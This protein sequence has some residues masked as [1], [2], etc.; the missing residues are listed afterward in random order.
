MGLAPSGGGAGA[1]AGDDVLPG[2]AEP[3]VVRGG[4]AGGDHRGG[5]GGGGAGGGDRRGGRRPDRALAAAK[6]QFTQVE[7]SLSE[8]TFL[9]AVDTVIAGVSGLAAVSVVR[10]DG[11]LSRSSGALLTR[12]W[13]DPLAVP[14]LAGA[15]QRT[16]DTRRASATGVLDLVGGQRFIVFDPV[17]PSDS[18]PPRAIL[19]AELEALPIIRS[20]LSQREDALAPS[21]YDV[22]DATGRRITTVP[23][24]RG[25]NRVTHAVG[26][27][28]TEWQL[29]VAYQPV[30]T[31]SFEAVSAAIR[32]SGVLLALGFALS[33]FFLW[34]T[35][36]AQQAEIRL[37]VEAERKAGENA[38]EAARRAA[39]AREVTDQLTAAQRTAL[40]LVG[41]QDPEEV[42]DIFLGAV[43]EVL[44]AD[45]ALLY[46]FEEHG[47]EAV[48]RRR[49]VLNP[50]RLPDSVSQ[51]D[52]QQVRVPVS[53]VPHLAEPIATGEPYVSAEEGSGGLG[54]AVPG[55]GRPAA[56]LA[57]PLTI[58]DHL[59]G[60]AVWECYTPGSKFDPSVTAF[61]R[62]VGA[63]A[64]ASLRAADLLDR[65]GRARQA[66]AREASRLATVLDRLADG[67]VLF[68][69]EGVP[70]RV[71]PAAE[72]L[73]GERV[74][75]T[76]LP[77]WPTTLGLQHGGRPLHGA[78]FILL[79]ALEGHRVEKFRF[80]VRRHGLDRF[81]AASAAPIVGDTESIQGVA[82]V[83]RDITDEHEYAE[84]LRHT[85]D[86]LQEQALLLE[87]MNDELK[88][89]TLAKDQFLAMMSHELRTPINAIIGYSDILEMGVHGGLNAKQRQMLTRVVETSRH[90]LGLV[91]DVLDLTKVAAGRMDLK[92]ETVAL[93]PVLMKAAHQVAPLAESKGLVVHVD[94]PDEHPR[95]GRRD[96][97]R[98]GRHQ[99]GLQRGEVHRGGERRDRRGDRG[100]PCAGPRAGHRPR[101]PAGRAG[102]RVR[103]VPPAGLEPLPPGGRIGARP[104]HLQAPGPPHGGRPE[105]GER[106]GGRNRL[107][108]GP[109]PRPV[110]AAGRLPGAELAAGHHAHDLAGEPG[111]VGPQG[112]AEDGQ[113]H[114]HRGQRRVERRRHHRRRRRA[115]HVGLAPNRQE[116]DRRLDDDGHDDEQQG[117]DR[118]PDEADEEELRVLHDGPRFMFIPMD[119]MSTYSS[120]VPTRDAPAPSSVR[121][122]VK[123]RMSP[124]VVA[125]TTIQKNGLVRLS[126]SSRREVRR[127]STGPA[128][129]PR[130]A[131]AAR[132]PEA[133]GED[134]HEVG[135]V[136][137]PGHARLVVGHALLQALDGRGVRLQLPVQDVR[138]AGRVQQHRQPHIRHQHVHRHHGAEQVIAHLE[139]LLHGRLVRAAADPA[140]G[141]RR[142]SPPDRVG[143]ARRTASGLI[144]E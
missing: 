75:T 93:A 99:P 45:Q 139:D 121:S 119:A 7:D 63:Q 79:R 104:G 96:P 39:E 33:L 68:D 126:R 89:A 70:V 117:V 36:S 135:Q 54:G 69:Q 47:D 123:E 58:G 80:T 115:A 132:H 116:E 19:A 83:V 142:Q 25:W 128:G 74:H 18:G 131:P 14:E 85:N 108:R 61:A 73:L 64:A 10:P 86:E 106:R 57:V 87:R 26:V 71:N 38:A 72:A 76:P 23:S 105:S 2:P 94:A 22:Y 24:P 49:I 98:P 53:L 136:R 82:L 66:A 77:A 92:V 65:V 6:V 29:T 43:G 127:P 48:G 90:L 4:A 103:G 140:P 41:S 3:A 51:D 97:P 35:V 88:A 134:L 84:M 137:D 40:R 32:L 118:D 56:L 62:A 21:F 1:A 52:F 107:P 120:A 13:S 12:T 81:Y 67:V 34:R 5:A 17:L 129:P 46:G 16:L 112:V 27:A 91:N 111:G 95:P 143:A 109:P 15:F 101:D 60:L 30:S 122:F 11:T 20:G 130:N 78:D 141:H 124:P 138:L 102:A 113:E 144:H 50:S 133:H 31:R 110:H 59:V 55:V 42:S 100:G 44:G 37:R 125:I 28:D 8:G 9:A 114:A